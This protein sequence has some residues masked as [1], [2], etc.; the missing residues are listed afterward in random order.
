MARDFYDGGLLPDSPEELSEIA[1]GRIT[2]ESYMSGDW[3]LGPYPQA[4]YKVPPDISWESYKPEL[5]RRKE[6]FDKL[7]NQGW[8]LW[9]WEIARA[10]GLP[11]NLVTKVNQ[12]S[13]PTC[14]GFSAAMAWERKMIYQLLTAPVRWEKINPMATWAITKNYSTK[15]GQSM[16]G[17]KL[18]TTKY[19][20]YAVTD[21]GIGDY[22]G[23][24]DRNIYEQNAAKAQARQ[25]CSCSIPRATVADIQLCLD[26][27]EIVAIGNGTAC[28]TSRIDGN[29]INLGVVGGSWAHATD[30][31]TIRYIR[32]KPYFHWSNS[33]GD[34]YKGSKEGDPAIGCW[35][36]AESLHKMLQGASCWV[37][38]YAEGFE[39]TDRLSSQ[40]VPPFVGYPDYVI[41]KH[42]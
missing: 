4:Q 23:R 13:Y 35:L 17:V 9:W 42:S 6:H 16:A 37:T 40:F 36:D 29:G 39:D 15:G 2:F 41:H 5:I 24:V 34:M 19:G 27:C 7:R 18:G 31:D 26:A 22:P 3:E 20:N 1:A 12:L 32:H 28:K 10:F 21:Q 11:M 8:C 33:W 30:Y 14:A 38:V 25:L